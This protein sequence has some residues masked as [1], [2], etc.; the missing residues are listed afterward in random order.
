[1]I[2]A[3]TREVVGGQL[4]LVKNMASAATATAKP[5]LAAG[6]GFVKGH[7]SAAASA[8]E[9]AAKPGLAAGYGFVKGQAEAAAADGAVGVGKAG[10]AIGGVAVA[11]YFLWP[12]ATGATM[13]APGAAGYVISRAAFLAN[14]KLYFHLLRTKGAVAAA[15][16]FA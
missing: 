14:P 12:T 11:A 16:V 10:L 9:A 3:S 4:N 1:M 13:N 6:Y 5:G 8:V 2:M 15:A 7:A